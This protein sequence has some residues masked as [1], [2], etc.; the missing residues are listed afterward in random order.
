MPKRKTLGKLEPITIG[1]T[2]VQYAALLRLSTK[3]DRSFSHLVRE[4][5]S[6]LLV[7]RGV[8]AMPEGA[9]PVRQE[10]QVSA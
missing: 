7:E 3:E 8:A 1:F 9:A 6:L 4:A 2:P 5:V 10:A